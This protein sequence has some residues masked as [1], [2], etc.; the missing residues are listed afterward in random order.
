[1]NIASFNINKFCGPYSNKGR[2]YN[3][4]NINFKTPIKEMISNLLKTEKDIVFLQEFMD[5]KFVNVKTLF[6]EDKYKIHSNVNINDPKWKSNVVAITLKDTFWKR[7]DIGDASH[8][9]KKI[10]MYLNVNDKDMK[11]V[12]FHNTD[13][14]IKYYI[15]EHF[16]KQDVDIILGDFDNM[17]WINTLNNKPEMC[18]RDLVTNDMVT[19]KPGQTAIDRIFVRKKVYDDAIIFNGVHETFLSD[20][21]L[22]CFSLNIWYVFKE[23]TKWYQITDM[24]RK[25]DSTAIKYI[26]L[27]YLHGDRG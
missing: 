16:N 25:L 5:N 22:V 19:Y 27:L 14:E 17:E 9:N 11:I 15:E 18:Y 13:D 4:R 6:S 3:P 20:H 21:N 2:Y 1:M 12:C 7:E 8:C 24:Q 26:N 23:C 10:K